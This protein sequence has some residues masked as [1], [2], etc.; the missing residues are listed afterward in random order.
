[1]LSGASKFHGFSLNKSLHVD[2][3]LLQS[4]LYVPLCFRPHKFAVSVEIEGMF[5]QVGV[6]PEDQPSLRFLWREDPS[7]KVMV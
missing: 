7:T 5:L 3:D 1:M 2:P 4:L 6:L